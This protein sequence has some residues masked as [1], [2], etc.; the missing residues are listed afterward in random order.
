MRLV[1]NAVG[2]A[3]LVLFAVAVN[4][5][6]LNESVA[7]PAVV[8][9]FLG[10]IVLGALW[11]VLW[12]AG[13]A[14]SGKLARPALANSMVGS[15]FF[16]GA[17]V[18]VYAFVARA[19]LSWDLTQEGRRDLAPQTVLVLQSLTEP[20][21]V[22]CFFVRAGDDRVRLAQEKTRRFLDRCG[23][24]TDRLEV[25]FIDPQEHPE[26]VQRYNAIGV[27]KSEVGSIL[28][29]SGPRQRE[30]PL[31]D[32]NARLEERDFVNALVNVTQKA[33]PRLYFLLGHG[34]WDLQSEDPK[35][36]GRTFIELLVRESYDVDV[37]ALQP[38]SPAVPADADVLVINGY[39]EDLR[40]PEIEAIAAFMDQGGRLMVLVNPLYQQRTALPSVERLRPFLSQKLGVEMPTNVLVSSETGGYQIAILPD[41][42][43]FPNYKPE[44]GENVEPFRGSYNA[45]H[46]ITRGMDKQIALNFVRSVESVD[47]LPGGVTYRVLLR[48]TPGTWAETDIDAIMNRRPIQREATE[49]AGPN[50]IAVA[51]T[52]QSEVPVAD[53][54]RARE[55]RA[56]IVGN[57][58]I[59][60]N[61]F[62]NYAGVQDFL[63]N[64][65]GWLTERE[66]IAIRPSG[67][68]EQPLLLTSRQERIVA[69]V[70]SLAAV[71]CVAL[72]GVGVF[73]WRRRYR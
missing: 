52:M 27:Q 72:V 55:A 62:M 20:V 11:F 31:S 5:A 47:E 63:L 49:T 33:S 46:P 50:P 28:L 68:I 43:I 67:G 64:S 17:L 10:S 73:V 39:T 4:L 34:G 45:T 54:S 60:A 25:A 58:Y 16:L 42:S 51:V 32:V 24:H 61:E 6:L 37:W 15:V 36:G 7:S 40:E 12:I 41:F 3:A 53:G 57:A 48:S 8:W 66:D 65:L 26:Q 2:V 70:A 18:M 19:E 71:Q 69:W 21:E 23:H 9:P 29:K 14:T 13:Q 35:Q 56:V 1:R 59:S 44:L 22:V 38:E 30:I